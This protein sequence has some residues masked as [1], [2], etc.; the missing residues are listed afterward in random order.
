M[1]YINYG[2]YLNTDAQQFT[3]TPL[4]FTESKNVAISWDDIP[5][6]GEEKSSGCTDIL[7]NK[8]PSLRTGTT[9]Q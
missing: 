2:N 3:G 4:H 7:P 9:F 5:S 8:S 1:S 6:E